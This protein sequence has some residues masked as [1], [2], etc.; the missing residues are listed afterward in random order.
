MSEWVN[1]DD[2]E[3]AFTPEKVAEVFSVQQGD[4]SSSG[5]ADAAALTYA[6]RMGTAEIE[7]VI[8]GAYAGKLDYIATTCPD[9]LKQL[10]LPC[11]MHQGMLRRPEFMRDPKQSPY[12]EV[13][14]QAREDAK[15]LREGYQRIAANVDPANVGGQITNSAPTVRKP[16]T[17]LADPRTGK[18]GFNDGSF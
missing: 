11:V 7:R 9:T 17:F 16:H 5:A 1:Q 15:G 12:F 6:I 13:W 2:L 18:G 8:L 4:G 10:V 3:K 14:K